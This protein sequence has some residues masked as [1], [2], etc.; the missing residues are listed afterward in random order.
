MEKR[1]R[2]KKITSL[3]FPRR[4]IRRV[5]AVVYVSYYNKWGWGS[6]Q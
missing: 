5:H 2:D 3:E 6:P 1:E 4:Q